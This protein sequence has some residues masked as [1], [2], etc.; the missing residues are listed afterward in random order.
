MKKIKKNNKKKKIIFIGVIVLLIL[1]AII[2]V[3]IFGCKKTDLVL[4]KDLDVEINSD[5]TLLSFVDEV[6]NGTVVTK[7]KEIDTSKL[8]N[9]NLVI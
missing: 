1:V 5:V 4:I 8:G 2:T 3:L 6:K 7:D 9:Q